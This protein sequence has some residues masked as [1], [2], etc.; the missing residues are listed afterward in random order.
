MQT[1]KRKTQTFTAQ[2]KELNE[3][4]AAEKVNLSKFAEKKENKKV[5]LSADDYAK[6]TPQE[7]YLYNFNNLK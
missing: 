4:P 5:E 3:Q 6:L 2:V 7:K 1:C